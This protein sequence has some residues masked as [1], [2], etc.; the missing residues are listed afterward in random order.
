MCSSY[1]VQG[2]LN[3]QPLIIIGAGRSG[4]NMLRDVLTK[5]DTFSTW[6]CDE[7]NYVWRY[8][9]RSFESD[10]LTEVQATPAI[11]YFIRSHFEQM[12]NKF[13]WPATAAQKV[14]V[15]KTCANSLRVGFVDAVL[16]EAKYVFLVR[17]GRDVVAS[18]MKRWKAPLDIPYLAAKA[19]YVPKSDLPYYAFKYLGT[20]LSKLR[21]SEASL[22]IWGP[23]FEGWKSVVE[24][25]DLQTV[26]THQWVRC[27]EQSSRALENIPKDRIYSLRYEDFVADPIAHVKGIIEFSGSSEPIDVITDACSSVF[28]GSIGKSGSDLSTDNLAL[29]AQKLRSMGYET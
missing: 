25:N 4:T 27:I 9:N 14:L 1:S 22:S 12:G 17:D 26:C 16:P 6:P 7:I 20:R 13:S 21:S 15:E 10:E 23:K 2:K 3:T 28:T 19:K 24:S 8:G 5:L 29:M 18:A 11:K